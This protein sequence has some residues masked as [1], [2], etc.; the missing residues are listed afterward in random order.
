[1]IN[2]IQTYRLFFKTAH[3]TQNEDKL[4]QYNLEINL[5]YSK[6]T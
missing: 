3:D 1:M 2:V 5:C 6:L 4:I